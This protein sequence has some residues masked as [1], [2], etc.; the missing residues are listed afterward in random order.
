M[1]DA[2]DRFIPLIVCAEFDSPI[3]ALLSLHVPHDEVM[4][5]VAAS[6][7]DEGRDCVATKVDGGRAVAVLLQTGGRWAAC[8]AYPRHAC[9]TRSE[10]ERR[11]GKLCKR[12]Q[13]GCIGVLSNS[14]WL[15]LLPAEA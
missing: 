13:R 12:H 4:D 15:A 9:A 5:L 10:A 11:L 8:N 14:E 7:L 2:T 3:D 1:S 6:W